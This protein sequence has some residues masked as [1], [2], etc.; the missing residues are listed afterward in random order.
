MKVYF[1]YR[2][3]NQPNERKKYSQIVLAKKE[4]TG[5]TV[6]SDFYFRVFSILWYIMTAKK[7]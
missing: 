5:K 2:D 6:Y 3:C 1:L 4:H 7:Q